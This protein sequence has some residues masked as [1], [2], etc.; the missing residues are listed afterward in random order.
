MNQVNPSPQSPLMR[1][2]RSNATAFVLTLG[3][4]GTFATGCQKIA[5]PEPVVQ[6]QGGEELK[7]VARKKSGMIAFSSQRD[8]DMSNRIYHMNH[9]GIGQSGLSLNE[10]GHNSYEPVWAPNMK[11]LAYHADGVG[12]RFDIFI[13]N[14]SGSVMENLTSHPGRDFQPSWSPD[15]QKIA[16]TSN[17]HESSNT[18]SMYEIYIMDLDGS[19]VERLTYTT[20]LPNGRGGVN[21]SPS[22]SP[23]GNEIV[24]VSTR[25]AQHEIYRIN[26]DGSNAQ[27]L[28][29]TFTGST[30]GGYNLNDQPVYS[31]S[32]NT[33]A[34]ISTR[35]GNT[36]L[37]T[38]DSNGSNVTKVTDFGLNGTQNP[39]WS[40]DGNW[41]TIAS[42]MNA[43]DPGQTDAEIYVI[44][45]DGGTI[46]QVT[47]NEFDD[48]E[49]S[50]GESVGAVS[51]TEL[52]FS[53]H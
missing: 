25:D 31:P 19:N 28:T 27:R 12:E 11:M 13:Q 21:T 8:G 22:W 39:S 26:V 30:I 41:M 44:S 43:T 50:W 3:L 18:S 23:D 14:R 40:F 49:P 24:F 15:G 6:I 45:P 5:Q 17:R 10:E 52:G 9:N 38:M 51:A 37:Y 36:E 34:F 2:L 32:G 53:T 29:S 48:L 20:D 42:R 35:D 16:F 7:A 47:D 4:C 1:V 33:I 46:F